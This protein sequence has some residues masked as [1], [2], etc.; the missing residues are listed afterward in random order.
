MSGHASRREL[1]LG[2]M[3]AGGAMIA[4][5]TLAM[6][7]RGRLRQALSLMTLGADTPIEECCRIARE[8]GT[9][10]IDF[11]DD[12]A[13]WPL[14]KQYGL[15]CTMLRADYGGGKSD[16][17]RREGPPGWHAIGLPEAQGAY[18]DELRR[19]IPIAAANGFPNLIALAGTRHRV[20]YEEGA[21]NAVAF[22][23]ALAPDLERH[24]VTLCIEI[25]NSKGMGGPPLSM[26]DHAE[27]GFDVCRR[28]ESKRVKILYDIFH[29]QMMDGDIATTIRK[30]IDL[31]GHIHVGGVPGRHEI[32]ETQELNYRFLARVIAEKGYTG[33]VAHEWMPSPG[34]DP[35]AVLKRAVEI[36]TV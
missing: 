7:G 34:A 1:L 35:R 30:N 11:I 24:G 33:Y 9:H 20:S 4:A 32:D 3:A 29:A 14:L 10:G 36:L 5:P 16:L 28:S 15:T 6:P 27:W 25:L 13:H 2:A 19:L 31:I 26:F 17:V 8:L 21:A 12:P 22:C 18:L 23:K